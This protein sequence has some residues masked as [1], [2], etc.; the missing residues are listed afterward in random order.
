MLVRNLRELARI[1]G[2]F[3]VEQ[4][5]PEFWSIPDETLGDN[6]V[7]LK[8]M[9]VN[10]PTIMTSAAISRMMINSILEAEVYNGVRI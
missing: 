9:R 10:E 2:V 7:N 3:G 5:V 1:L 6:L 8:I 4:H